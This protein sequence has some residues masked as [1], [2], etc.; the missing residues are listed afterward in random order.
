[1]D[2]LLQTQ[3]VQMSPRDVIAMNVDTNAVQDGQHRLQV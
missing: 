1:M 3:Y 2:A